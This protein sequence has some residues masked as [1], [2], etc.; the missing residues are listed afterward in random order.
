[1]LVDFGDGMTLD[2]E[3]KPIL[4]DLRDE[5]EQPWRS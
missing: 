2:E 4:V 3:P 1:M 5:K